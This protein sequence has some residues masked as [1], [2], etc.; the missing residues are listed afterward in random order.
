TRVSGPS[1]GETCVLYGN[2][3]GTLDPAACESPDVAPTGVQLGDVNDDGVLDVVEGSY[4]S[5]NDG[6]PG[7]IYVGVRAGGVQGGLGT[8]HNYASGGSNAGALVLGDIDRDGLLD[9]IVP[10]P[11]FGAGGSGVCVLGNQLPR[12]G[13]DGCPGDACPCGN[14]G[15]GEHGCQNSASTGGA[16]LEGSGVAS[17]ANDS[18]HLFSSS[19]LPSSL[20]LFIQ[21]N[22]AIPATSFGDG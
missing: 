6:T 22:A 13:T 2:A 12:L 21:G 17:L 14:D 18:A 7:G 5:D 9:A 10:G 16:R 3:A 11:F 4:T 15:V 19:G 20:T 8:L 1:G